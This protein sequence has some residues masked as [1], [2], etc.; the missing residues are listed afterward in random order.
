MSN[1]LYALQI[2]LPSVVSYT[3]SKSIPKG[4][5]SVGTFHA[6]TSPPETPKIL[7]ALYTLMWWYV[8]KLLNSV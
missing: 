5:I 6:G 3:S 7:L 8:Y 2:T 4:L 1:F